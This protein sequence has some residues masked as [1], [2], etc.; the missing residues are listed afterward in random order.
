MACPYFLPK[1][2]AQHPS[3]PLPARSPLGA[4]YGGSCVADQQHQ[5]DPDELYDFCN[6]GYA[7]G[8]CSRFPSEAEADAVRFS[9]HC[10]KLLFILEKDYAPVRHGEAQTEGGVIEV[11]A[12][13]FS[14]NLSR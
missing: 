14:D 5:P 13:A 8:R 4:P 2:K 1:A 12:R 6:A 9:L 10:G 7:R 3:R 11:Q